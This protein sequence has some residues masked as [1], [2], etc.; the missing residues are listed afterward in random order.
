MS[1]AMFVLSKVFAIS[2]PSHTNIYKLL[3][4]MSAGHETTSGALVWATLTLCLHPSV[5]VR[6]RSEIQSQIQHS[7]PP[8]FAELESLTY[9]NAFLKE[10]LRCF[11]PTIMVPRTPVKDLTLCGT[12]IPVGTICLLDPQSIQFNPTIWGP[13]AE[14]FKPERHFPD[15]PSAVE[16]PLSRDPYASETFSNGPR[17]C[18]GKLFASLEFKSLMVELLRNFEMVRG[19]NTNGERLKEGDECGP[20]EEGLEGVFAGVKLRNFMTLRPQEGVWIRFKPVEN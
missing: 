17:I 6:L 15:H 13:D 11:S 3:N 8:S 1:W 2:T 7:N 20:D 14:F 4:F 9:M 18:I 19:W 5:Q 10:I 16:Y 12:V